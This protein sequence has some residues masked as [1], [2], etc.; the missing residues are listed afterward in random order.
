MR[1]L[2]HGHE[3]VWPASLAVLIALAAYLVLPAR[4]VIQPRWLIPA[5]EA[6]LLFPLTV[7]H[8]HRHHEEDRLVRA[9]SMGLIG[10]LSLANAVSTGLLVHDLL[11]GAGFGGRQLVYSAMELWL[12]NV[13]VFS[14][15]FWEIDRGGPGVRA[16][17][18]KLIPDFGFPQ[19]FTPEVAPPGWRPHYIDYL[20]VSLTNA[21]A[22]S[23][24]DTM[25]L[26][27]RAKAIMALESLVSIVTVVV[28]AARA[29]NILS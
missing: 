22:F 26:T 15:W 3:R 23:P 20:Y 12:T 2:P 17:E 27:R 28:V 16:G 19:M 7:T 5:I 25:P 24:T 21:A 1:A 8:P 4:L 18:Q 6:A 11:S 9:A 13:L 14:L 29:V 10:L